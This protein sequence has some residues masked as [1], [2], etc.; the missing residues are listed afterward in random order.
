MFQS[1]FTLAPYSPD[2][3]N[4][5]TGISNAVNT[6]LG[7]TYGYDALSRLKT[8]TSASGNQTFYWDENSNKTRQTWTSD[9]YLTVN[10]ANNRIM[11]M[12]SHGYTYDSRGNRATQSYGGSVA[13]YSY[14]GFNRM[15]GISRNA[16]TSYAEPNY[17]TVSLPAG[18]NSYGYNAFNERVW[19]QT[20]SLGSTRFVYG[21]GSALLG[22][23]RESDGQWS[24]YLWFNGELAGL[25][26]GSTLYFAHNDHLGRP[27]V[28]TNSAKAVVWRA[29]NYAFDRAVTLDSIGGLNIGFPGQYYDRETNL[30]YNINRYYDARLGTYTQSD[31]IGLGGGLNTYAYV[32][33]NPVS[34]VDPFGLLTK[35][36]CAALK[37]LIEHD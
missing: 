19:K 15:T 32:G 30:W 13:T 31:P 8:V 18:G 1:K 9:E 29:S 7:Q 21:P 5:S 10:T 28:V 2:T 26:R 34:F 22:E 23:R 36:N 16:A 27:E 20:A 24:S 17:T 14:D 6:S 35:E 11:A 37:K 12:A 3:S 4:R 25:V 33:G